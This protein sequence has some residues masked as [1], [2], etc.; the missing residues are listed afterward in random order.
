[1]PSWATTTQADSRLGRFPLRAIPAKADSRLGHPHCKPIPTSAEHRVSVAWREIN[2]GR[3]RRRQLSLQQAAVR[4][5]EDYSAAAP[6]GTL[7]GVGYPRCPRGPGSLPQSTQST[8]P[9]YPPCCAYR[10]RERTRRAC[11]PSTGCLAPACVPRVRTPG[12]PRP[13]RLG[14][15]GLL[16]PPVGTDCAGWATTAAC[17]YGLPCHAVAMP[18]WTDS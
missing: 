12:G 17:M 4:S 7:E 6:P 18:R 14:R 15:A 10:R 1:M 11:T 8:Y 5:R 3:R 13:H 16:R 2:N 9:E